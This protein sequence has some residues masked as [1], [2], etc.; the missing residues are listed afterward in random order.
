[1]TDKHRTPVSR[2]KEAEGRNPPKN[3]ENPLNDTVY[4]IQNENDVLRMKYTWHHIG[5]TS[6]TSRSRNLKYNCKSALT[7]SSLGRAKSI[8]STTASRATLTSRTYK[9]KIKRNSFSKN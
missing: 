2:V 1:M 5:T 7:I 9:S 8:M 4:L 3:K 6:S